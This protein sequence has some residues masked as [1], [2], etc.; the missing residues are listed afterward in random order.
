MNITADNAGNLVSSVA[1]V[2]QVF[3]LDDQNADNFNIITTIY[4]G[5][6]NLIADN[7]TK[8]QVTS[9]VSYCG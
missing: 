6:D 5:I 2:I 3:S 1:D 9:N 8:F 4:D 7:G